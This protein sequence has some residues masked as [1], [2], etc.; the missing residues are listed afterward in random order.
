MTVT[1]DQSTV[2]P[3][4]AT[5]YATIAIVPTTITKMLAGVGAG[6]KVA[7]VD[8]DQISVS[9][10]TA[11]G[12]GGIPIASIPDPGP[13]T[14]NLNSSTSVTLAESTEVLRQDDLSDTIN[15]TPQIPATPD[16][17][18]Y[19]VS[20]KCKITNAGQSKVLSN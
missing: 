19:P 9:A 11:I 12:P 6:R 4:G 7:H 20:F 17:I 18:D 16:P 8:G 15:A 10:I 13:Y 1:V 14:S 5:V 3:A 2:I